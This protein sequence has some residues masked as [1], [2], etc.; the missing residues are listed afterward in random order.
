MSEVQHQARKEVILNKVEILEEL[1]LK[2]LAQKFRLVKIEIIVI[3]KISLGKK[4]F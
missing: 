3:K 4:E 1:L 2:A